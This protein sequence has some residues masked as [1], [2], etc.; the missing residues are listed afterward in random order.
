MPG[1][2]SFKYMT[3]PCTHVQ[4]QGLADESSL[5]TCI[6]QTISQ[7]GLSPIAIL[8][9][10]R[11]NPLVKLQIKHQIESSVHR[12]DRLLFHGAYQKE[13]TTPQSRKNG[14]H[15]LQVRFPDPKT[16]AWSCFKVQPH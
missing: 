13:E 4:A 3:Y 2:I 15:Y 8:D 14:V 12:V 1:T 10:R 9:P 11:R 16:I 7:F 6:H 5:S